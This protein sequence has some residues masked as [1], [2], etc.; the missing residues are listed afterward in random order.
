MKRYC[1]NQ[2]R[3]KKKGENKKMKSKKLLSLVVVVAMLVSV[4]GVMGVSANRVVDSADGLTV[5]TVNNG[6][7]F[8]IAV[9]GAAAQTTVMMFDITAMASIISG[10]PWTNQ[11]I[12]YVNQI[13]AAQAANWPIL[14]DAERTIGSDDV[15]VL[16]VESYFLIRVGGVGEP[17]Q[18][19]V[20]TGLYVENDFETS[21]V[22][23]VALGANATVAGAHVEGT[24]GAVT[25]TSANLPSWLTLSADGALSGT[26]DVVFGQDEDEV[27]VT[28]DVTATDSR[29]RT[30]TF[31]VAM[32][33]FAE[34][35][36]ANWDAR[37][38]FMPVPAA[39]AFGITNARR[40]FLVPEGV[41][42]G[43]VAPTDMIPELLVDGGIFW[44]IERGGW[45]VVIVTTETGTTHADLESIA[46]NETLIVWHDAASATTAG[47]S[48]TVLGRYGNANVTA[49][50]TL[51]GPAVTRARQMGVGA[52]TALVEGNVNRT[53]LESR[54]AID[55]NATSNPTIPGPVITTIRQM[56][57]GAPM[58]PAIVTNFSD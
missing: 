40:L 57:A 21:G 3:N 31:T 58:I 48:Q 53:N 15:R 30:V 39:G 50:A 4:V 34:A 8:N 14:S 2:E 45:D 7:D 24:V 42:M 37:S 35:Q 11:P 44:S 5:T 17:L 27:I 19:L 6:A 52:F 13:T 36:G 23:D 16:D 43:A 12:A 33:V 47:V 29:N 1:Y 25:F 26:P 32:T 20:H 56:G 49:V 38:R 46:N 55:L 41:A 9:D 10:I 28:F 22:Y 18:A 54:M 51:P